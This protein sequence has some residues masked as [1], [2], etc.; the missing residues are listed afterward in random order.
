MQLGIWIDIR[1][2]QD[3]PRLFEQVADMGFG[4]VQAH[5]PAGCD[6][7]LARRARRAAARSGV[8]I[9]A[10]SGYANPLRPADAPMGFTQ[11]AL[12]DL[13]ALLPALDS[14]RVVTWSGTCAAS[15]FE[16]DPENQGPAAWDTLRRAVDDLFPLLDANDA[17]LVFEP[18]F[19]H[20][21]DTPE[22][23]VAFCEEVGSPY[24]RVVLDPPNL[25]PPGMWQQQSELLPPLVAALA[26]YT[27]LIHLKDM[28]LRGAALD[29]P[30]PGEGVLDYPTFLGA[31][32][33]AEISAP[34]VIEHV[35]LERAARARRFVLAHLRSAVAPAL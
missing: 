7:A 6:A 13:V 18:F 21:L 3:V 23:I 9:V 10:V 14:R 32:I 11:A 20:V 22:R 30:G 35:A 26:P 15:L 27:G 2:E 5:F 1:P 28:R 19:A 17:I 29:L 12:A 24:V 25:L 16:E 8:E 34:L 4:A 31:V 33:R